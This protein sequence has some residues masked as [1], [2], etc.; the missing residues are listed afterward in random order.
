M[1]KLI[2][3]LPLFIFISGCVAYDYLFTTTPADALDNEDFFWKHDTS[4]IFNYHF[5]AE[6][7]TPDNLIKIISI[8]DKKYNR[9]LELLGET[10]YPHQID[11]FIVN[12]RER[13]NRLI[14]YRLN[15]AAYPRFNALYAVYNDKINAVGGHELN[16]IIAFNMWG[17]QSDKVLSEG[18]AVY[19]DDKWHGNNLHGL[20]RY[21]ISEN[22]FVALHDLIDNYSDYTPMITYPEAG[23]FVKLLYE[24]Y[25]RAKFKMLWKSGVDNLPEIYRNE[26]EVLE[27]DWR[28]T[29]ITADTSG[30][31]YSL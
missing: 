17:N 21:L 31:K 18:F 2:L 5:E 12:S 16:H 8:T 22:K 10:V 20:C 6:F 9:I 13:M 23:S 14:G 7:L 15:A 28:Q 19:T 1:R 27:A 24:K 30:I 26:I 11:Y 3:T 4:G 29:I 25:G